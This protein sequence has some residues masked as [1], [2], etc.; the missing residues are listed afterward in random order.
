MTH[1]IAVALAFGIVLGLLMAAL[2]AR[3]R[4]RRRWQ[5]LVVIA[6]I[7]LAGSVALQVDIIERVAVIL[8][9]AAMIVVYLAAQAITRARRRASMHAD[10]TPTD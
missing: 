10:Q 9:W 6:G 5:A 1:Q 3:A 2:E 8:G 7:T 4:G